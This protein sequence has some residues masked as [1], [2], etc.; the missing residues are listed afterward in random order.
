MFAPSSRLIACLV[1]EGLMLATYLPVSNLGP[2]ADLG[3]VALLT[4]QDLSI[5]VALAHTPPTDQHCSIL[6]LNPLDL[7]CPI[8]VSTIE[9]ASTMPAQLTECLCPSTLMRLV[10]TRIGAVDNALLQEI[11]AELDSCVEH[12]TH[13]LVHPRPEPTL[14]STAIEW[15]QSIIEGQ[16]IHPMHKCRYT[17]APTP[18][19]EPETDLHN[20]TL[21]LV[22][23]PADAVV[24]S[25]EYLVV[26][27]KLVP[28][29]MVPIGRVPILV[30]PLQVPNVVSKFSEA[31][32]HPFTVPAL[33]QS[34]LRAVILPGLCGFAFKIPFSIKL[35]SS[36][37][38]CSP[39]STSIG[40]SLAR[41]LDRIV[42]K[43]N[44]LRIAA[45]HSTVRSKHSDFDIAK[46]LA[47][48][49]RDEFDAALRER[50]EAVIVC[51]ALTER[52]DGH[53]ARIINLC[54]LDTRESRLEFLRI[55]V[56]LA[57]KAFL[58]PVIEHGF[59]FEAHQQNTL[60]RLRIPSPGDDSPVYPIGLI[61]RDFGGVRF[62]PDTLFKSTGM[63]VSLL[64][65]N[66][67]EAPDL[68]KVYKRL[69][70]SLIQ[71]HL[72]PLIRALGLH[73]SGE[74]WRIVRTQ[75][76]E[77]FKPGDIGHDLWLSSDTC[78]WKCLV[79]MRLKNLD[80]VSI[81]RDVPNV[82]LYRGE[83]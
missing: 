24:V 68:K 57:F 33:A 72:H 1:N 21:R 34:S 12:M 10:A 30:H 49:I 65:G 26:M 28:A 71:M 18:R 3:P 40:P 19:I 31:T 17:V 66:A 35:T 62:H 4:L 47:C 52:P 39:W 41:V 78:Q 20:L 53:T 56:D 54:N 29:D 32:F 42:P 79:R 63:R 46:H 25:G 82:L 36:L 16:N 38:T 9:T 59:A 8:F 48:I 61:I 6:F 14:H 77:Y 23:M 37:R 45:E 50:N 13:L 67:N 75:L 55:F 74:G 43:S 73:Y 58:V 60:V 81:D 2:T 27:A 7:Q 15:E 22:S 76:E 51:A 11:C 5:V 70:H 80:T 69:Y 64:P 83:P 44:V